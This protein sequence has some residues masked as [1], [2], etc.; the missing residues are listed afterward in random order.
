MNET[1][2]G[3]DQEALNRDYEHFILLHDQCIEALKTAPKTIASMGI[4]RRPI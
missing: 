1:L 4:V 2:N 3:F